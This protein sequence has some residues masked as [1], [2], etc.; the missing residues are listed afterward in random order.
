M[1][2][3]KHVILSNKVYEELLNFLSLIPYKDVAQI[4]SNTVTD[5]NM[6]KTTLS[7]ISVDKL[8]ESEV[9]DKAPLE[10]VE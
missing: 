10:V 1:E 3:V 7:I 9:E 2:E 8:V 4:I 5:A 6:N